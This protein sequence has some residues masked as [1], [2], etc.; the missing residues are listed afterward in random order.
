[1]GLP[2]LALLGAFEVMKELDIPA[3]GGKDSMSGSWHEIDVPPSLVSFAVNTADSQKVVSREFKQANSRI[4]LTK[5]ACD[6]QGMIDF[7]QFARVMQAFAALHQDGKVLAASAVSE[8]GIRFTLDDMALGNGLGLEIKP[9]LLDKFIP[10]S[11]V[12]KC[13]QIWIMTQICLKKSGAPL[14]MVVIRL[15]H[16]HAK[17]TMRQYTEIFW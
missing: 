4:L 13:P 5:I 10:G 8:H 9:E 7:E 2:F 11:I 3:I 12:L 14:K 16:R 17:R 15:W 6:A 1:M